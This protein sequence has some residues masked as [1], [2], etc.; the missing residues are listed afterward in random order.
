MRTDP[1]DAI[2]R[3]CLFVAGH[4]NRWSTDTE[5]VTRSDSR[6]RPV[7]RLIP[8]TSVCIGS[9]ETRST[10]RPLTVGPC[11]R[12]VRNQPSGYKRPMTF[13][14]YAVSRDS[15]IEIN[16]GN[17]LAGVGSLRIGGGA[18]TWTVTE[19]SRQGIRR[20]TC[21]TA[22]PCPPHH[23]AVSSCSI[24]AGSRSIPMPGVSGALDH[25]ALGPD[26]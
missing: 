4:D 19:L 20:R 16:Q 11:C 8:S 5:Y 2:K 25:A 9:C 22:S 24:L 15:S 18:F 7:C 23:V 12:R 13:F 21:K 17:S 10:L 14:G 1:R 26:G 3:P 6:R